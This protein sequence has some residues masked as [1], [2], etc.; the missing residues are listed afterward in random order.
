MDSEESQIIVPPSFVELFLEPGRARPTAT[1]AH[2]TL[3][4]E[5]CEDLA[6]LLCQRSQE[7]RADLGV[8]EDDVLERMRVGLQG[9]DSGVDAGEARW[10]FTRLLELLG[11]A[12]DPD[13]LRGD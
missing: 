11:H 1:R 6:Q 4:Y 10:V 7:I 8:T 5:F 13:R 3:R 9:A 12:P 2:I